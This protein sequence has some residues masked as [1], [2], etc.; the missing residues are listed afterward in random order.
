MWGQSK[1]ASS[2]TMA[3]V[4]VTL[5]SLTAVWA[6]IYYIYLNKN[7]GSDSSCTFREIC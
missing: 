2:A 1:Q 6:V 3:L 5:G 7:G 4:Y